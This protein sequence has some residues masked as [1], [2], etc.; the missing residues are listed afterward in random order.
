MPPLFLFAIFSVLQWMGLADAFKN[1]DDWAHQRIALED[2]SIHFRYA[3]S[4]PPVLL[5]H[6]NPQFSLTWRTIGPLLAENYT[7][8]AVDNRGAGDS[9]LPPDGNYT[10]MA[11]AEDLKSVMD[12]LNITSTYVLS[13]DMGAGMATALAVKHPDLVRRLVVTEYLLPGYGFELARTPGPYWDLY[14]NW[15]LAFFSVTDAAEF[16]ISGKER[17]VLEWYFYHGSY[18]GATSFSED[19]V[20]RY[21]SS[22][23]KPGFL[24][25]MLAPFENKAVAAAASFF[26]GTLGKSRLQTP[27]LAMGGE[28]SLGPFAKQVWGNVTSDLETDVIPKAGHWIAD[29]NPVWVA[30]RVKKFFSEETSKPPSVDLSTLTDKATLTV[31]YFGT[32]QN[33]ALAG[34]A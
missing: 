1:F 24:R 3:G 19:I 2:V 4:G 34:S 17:Q 31:G 27:T 20:N 29:E 30:R 22:I 11:S 14:A 6:G 7:V 23:S 9:S 10:V 5:V 26:Q 16:F 15:Q 8:I 21:A 12:F 13:H 25:A 18:S 28:A 33:V 32:L